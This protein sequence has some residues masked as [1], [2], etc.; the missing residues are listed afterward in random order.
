MDD[1]SAQALKEGAILKLRAEGR[2][3]VRQTPP[4]LGSVAIVNWSRKW[5]ELW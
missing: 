3:K 5:W 1:G 2:G 4:T